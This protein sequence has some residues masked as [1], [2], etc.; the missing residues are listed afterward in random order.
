MTDESKSRCQQKSRGFPLRVS[1]RKASRKN[2]LKVNLPSNVPRKILD[3]ISEN[4]TLINVTG[5]VYVTVNNRKDEKYEPGQN[6]ENDFWQNRHQTQTVEN[7]EK[8][9]PSAVCGWSNSP[10]SF[11]SRPTPCDPS[12]VCKAPKTPCCNLET[13]CCPQI[14][15][16]NCK[17]STFDA[18]L[19]ARCGNPLF[20]AERKLAA[21]RQFHLTCFTCHTC[22]K[23]LDSFSYF[24]KSQEIFC[25]SC[26][27]KRYGL[28][29]YGF[30]VAPGALNTA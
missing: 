20:H 2:N 11:C 8:S 3:E 5:P 22:N 30:G 29:G 15:T 9:K 14:K 19:C 28:R 4:E 13:Q 6:S 7:Q 24:Q 17:N 10:Q 1:K 27:A 21:G 16:N 12:S 18:E 23:S 26:Y 25:R